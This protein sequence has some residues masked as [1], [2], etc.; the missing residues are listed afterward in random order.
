MNQER[1][2]QTQQQKKKQK[3]L[4]NILMIAMIAVIAFCSVMAVISGDG[5]AVVIPAPRWSL[6]KSAELPILSEAA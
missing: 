3:K 6:R 2:M 5:S 4:F 1:K